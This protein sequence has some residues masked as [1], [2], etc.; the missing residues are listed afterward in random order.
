MENWK[1]NISG[2]KVIWIVVVLL[3][4]LSLLT[5]Y[6]S[7]VTLAYKFQ[8]G[9]VYY[10]MI[11]H[12]LILITGLG[13]MYASSKLNYIYYSRIFQIMLYIAIPLL[14]VTLFIGENINQASRVLRIPLIG[15][16]F[17][18]SDLAKLTLIVYL[19]RQLSIKQDE[20]KDLKK[21]FVPLIIPVVLAVILIMPANFSTAA[22]V[23]TISIVLLFVGRIRLIHLA[24]FIGAGIIAVAI[25]VAILS[26]MPEGYQWRYPTWKKR[27]ESYFGNKEKGEKTT[28]E[29][30]YQV[31]QAKIAIAS[32][33]IIWGKG[34]GNSTQ[35][36]FLPHP[37]SDFIY[38]II[39]EEY[40]L[41]AGAIVVLLYLI[42]FFRTIRIALKSPTLFGSLMV[43]GMGFS[44]VFQ[45]MINMGV[46]V[47]LLP[48]TGQPLPLVSMGGTSLWFSSL[49]IGIILSVSRETSVKK[50]VELN[51]DNDGLN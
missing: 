28:K 14:L 21:I 2:D 6:S 51:V 30:P 47:G 34:P 50:T 42:L 1:V 13:L 36:H 11:K 23:L 22:I 44:L 29:I 39:I 31:M 33:G 24:G 46:A 25:M 10:Y 40:G 45:A 48:V 17:Q 49:A 20:I 4:L 9:N 37:Y 8:Q 12:A 35:R 27:I 5:V 43:I 16:T 26:M 7:T 38:A 18:T 32:G 3:S 15:L 41:V 19:A